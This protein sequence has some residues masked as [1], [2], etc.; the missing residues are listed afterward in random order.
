MT[1]PG[2]TC[3]FYHPVKGDIV[4]GI[5]ER[6]R[7]DDWM[8]DI[9]YSHP[10]VLPQ[11]A[12]EG[13]TKRNCHKFQK[14]DLV[15]AFVEDVPDAG[16]TLLS[17]VPRK[18]KESLGPLAGGTLLRMR[19]AD[20]EK[21]KSVGFFEAL[22]SR[23]V[24]M[25]VAFGANGRAYI[26]SGDASV[27]VQ[28]AHCIKTALPTDAPLECFVQMLAKVDLSRV[29]GTDSSVPVSVRVSK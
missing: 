19:P 8:V 12:F 26:D 17:C 5:V 22:T 20:I 2:H 16:E 21:V 28:V 18:T 15:L 6:R 13:A 4:V 25:R 3:A 23:K 29:L 14:G 7:N 27:T 24:P 11:L 10:A 1:Q 9:G